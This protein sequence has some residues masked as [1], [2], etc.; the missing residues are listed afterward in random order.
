MDIDGPG[1]P[2]IDDFFEHLS[3]GRA[4]STVRRY[5]RVR[6]RLY[7]FLDVDDMASWLTPDEVVLL[8]AEREFDR[9]GALLRLLGADGLVRCLP[10][11]VAEQRLPTTAAEARMQVSVTGRLLRHLE[12]IDAGSRDMRYD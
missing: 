7:D 12:R 10:G 8:A 2:L 6:L 11:L 5:A 9:D 1:W 4:A 3:T